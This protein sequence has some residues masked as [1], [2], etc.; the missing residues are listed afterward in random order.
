MSIVQQPT[1]FDIDILMQLDIKERFSEIF[2]PIEFGRILTLF[3]KENSVGAPITVNYEACFRAITAR[4]LEGI[5]TV[6]SLVSRLNEDLEFKLSLG[7]L[8]SERIPSEATFCRIF[9]TLSADSYALEMIN[10]AVLKIADA[11]YAIF[12][13]DVAIDATAVLAH[14][15]PHKTDNPQISSTTEQLE[16]T[17]EAIEQEL[18]VYS[19]WGVKKNSQG[20]NN[21][22][23]GYKGHFAVSTRSQF[24]LTQI[25]S[26]AF[27]AD[28]NVAIPLIRRLSSLGIQNVHILMDK[29]YDANAIYR[30][31]HKHHFEPIIDLKKVPKNNGEVDNF[32]TPTCL[33]EHSYK[34]DSVDK[35]YDAL[36][37]VKP[38]GHCKECP[39]QFEGMCQKVIKV[40]RSDDYRKYAN[41]AR[42]SIAWNN[43]YNK[44]SSVERVNAYL[45][46]FFQLNQTRFVE[47]EKVRIQ[48]LLIQ[49]AYNA[50][51]LATLNVANR[52]I[53]KGIAA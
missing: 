2:S 41:P 21:Y 14:T 11:S 53:E 26:S 30:E 23:Y 50:K 39:L 31:A 15:H 19:S 13:E 27:V 16:M 42:G 33:L 4:Y 35:R 38:S 46:Q 17:N 51:K 34:F 48:H 8:Y 6:K 43:L 7:F 45:K 36:K 24:L 37:F 44:R 18:T 47:G 10:Q 32:F 40:K 12:S 20:K 1:L 29:G 22:W 5:P 9:K 52:F 28:I 3:Q 49:L 25:T